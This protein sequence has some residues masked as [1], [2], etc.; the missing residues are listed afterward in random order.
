MWSFKNV[1]VEFS[2]FFYHTKYCLKTPGNYAPTHYILSK[3][4]TVLR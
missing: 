3:G 2:C 4:V 1:I